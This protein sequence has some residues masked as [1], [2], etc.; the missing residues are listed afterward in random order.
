MGNLFAHD[1]QTKRDN[2]DGT[3]TY[4]SDQGHGITLPKGSGLAGPIGSWQD[5]FAA[6]G[7]MKTFGNNPYFENY[8]P[9]EGDLSLGGGSGGSPLDN[10][11]GPTEGFGPPDGYAP[12]TGGGGDPFGPPSGGGGGAPPMD[13]GGPPA[14]L[15]DIPSSPWENGGQFDPMGYE[16]SSNQD[17]YAQQLANARGQQ[18]RNQLREGVAR[19]RQ[20]KIDQQRH[21]QFE[22]NANKGAWQW[23]GGRDQ[24]RPTLGTEGSEAGINPL[25]KKGMTNYD[26]FRAVSGGMGD[27]ARGYLEK[28]LSAPANEGDSAWSRMLLNGVTSDEFMQRLGNVK[29]PEAFRQLYNI[30]S[31]GGGPGMSAPPGYALPINWGGGSNGG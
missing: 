22:K 7:A 31:T 12:P 11:P 16:G 19:Q 28:H 6:G 23:A 1:G 8:Q 3:V 4:I 27:A 10:P 5:D 20:G 25:V 30:A 2:K 15:S 26:L 14:D 17:F 18:F 9:G 13:W 24:F 29:H 21:Q